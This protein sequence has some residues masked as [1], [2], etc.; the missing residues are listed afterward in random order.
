MLDRMVHP[1]ILLNAEGAKAWA[2]LGYGVRPRGVS[3][4]PS[5]KAGEAGANKLEARE[6]DAGIRSTSILVVTF[7]CHPNM[8]GGIF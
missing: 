1:R 7:Q 3:R 6:R 8:V 4:K 5:S 2:S